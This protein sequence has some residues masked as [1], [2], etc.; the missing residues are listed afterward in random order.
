MVGKMWDNSKK[1]M[2]SLL[3]YHSG[4][5]RPQSREIDP[6]TIVNIGMKIWQFIKDNA[7]TLNV[8]RSS[9]SAVPVISK[10]KP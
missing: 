9:A 7:P 5:H 8:S 4:E 2:L 3:S 1:L 6:A 10:L